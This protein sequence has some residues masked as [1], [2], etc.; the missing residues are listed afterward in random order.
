MVADA[1]RELRARRRDLEREFDD[2]LRDLKAQHKRQMDRLQQDRAEWESYRREQAKEL[3]DRREA[4]RRRLD[5]RVKAEEHQAEERH[6]LAELRQTVA[7]LREARLEDTNAIRKLEERVEKARVRFGAAQRR[8]RWL[9]L[10][11]VLGGIAVIA[12]AIRAGDRGTVGL[13]VVFVAVVLVLELAGLV[14]G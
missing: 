4:V 1:E 2:K 13:A 3:A 10:V 9:A 7:E 14:R 6:D 11:A 5:N 12:S 8:R